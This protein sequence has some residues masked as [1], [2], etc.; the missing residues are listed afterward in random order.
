MEGRA[1]AEDNG[2]L[3]LYQVSQMAILAMNGLNRWND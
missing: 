1:M 3:I 2:L